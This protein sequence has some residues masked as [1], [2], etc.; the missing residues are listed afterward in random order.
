[1]D[2]AYTWTVSKCITIETGF[3]VLAHAIESYMAVNANAFLKWQL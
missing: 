1:V 3:D 2:T